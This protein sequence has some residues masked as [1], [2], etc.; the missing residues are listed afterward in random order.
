MNIKSSSSIERVL[1]NHRSMYD[2]WRKTGKNLLDNHRLLAR[3]NIES[4]PVYPS[5]FIDE[6]TEAQIT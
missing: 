4:Y 2:T 6:E 1:E 5:Q 3:R